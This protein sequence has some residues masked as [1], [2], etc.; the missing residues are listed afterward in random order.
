MKYWEGQKVS[1]AGLHGTVRKVHLQ[2][3]PIR[4]WSEE[5][6]EECFFRNQVTSSYIEV[7]FGREAR[8]SVGQGNIFFNWPYL[9]FTLEGQ[10]LSYPFG[11]PT[12]VS[13]EGPEAA[14]DESWESNAY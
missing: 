6:R 12:L 3:A 5:S 11:T 7:M 8:D 14:V 9:K 1:Y 10:L 4:Q 13:A 2:D